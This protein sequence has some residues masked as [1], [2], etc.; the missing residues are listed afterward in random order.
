MNNKIKE[1]RF[2]FNSHNITIK[3]VEKQLNNTYIIIYIYIY[4]IRYC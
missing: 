3:Y 1:H 4:I 2:T